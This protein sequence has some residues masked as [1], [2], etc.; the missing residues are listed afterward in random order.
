MYC[1][2]DTHALLWY[3]TG[4][5]RLSARGRF[6]FTSAEKGEAT[7]D[8]DFRFRFT[9]EGVENDL[10]L[11]QMRAYDRKRLLRKIGVMPKSDFQ[12]MLNVIKTLL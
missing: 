5:T 3:V 12:K 8:I 7:K 10:L 9:L 2:T 4:D 11:L 6:I 1:V